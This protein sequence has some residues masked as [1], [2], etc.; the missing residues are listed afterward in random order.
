MREVPMAK[1]WAR[2]G[3]S[4]RCNGEGSQVFRIGRILGDAASLID[5]RG[6]MHGWKSISQLTDTG[7]EPAAV[8][9]FPNQWEAK[10]E[11]ARLEKEV[12]RLEGL[13]V[14]LTEPLIKLTPA[15]DYCVELPL[16]NAEGETVFRPEYFGTY[17]EAVARLNEHL[18]LECDTL[19]I[20]PRRSL[21]T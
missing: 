9:E 19:G 21:T 18:G 2:E 1:S 7:L 20:Y 4:C 12:A 16:R 6:R 15:E 3:A 13:V 17:S 8:R 14:L 10:K 5:A 11:V